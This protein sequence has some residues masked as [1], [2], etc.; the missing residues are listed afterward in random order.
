MLVRSRGRGVNRLIR[1]FHNPG[2]SRTEK[3]KRIRFGRRAMALIGGLA[4]LSVFSAVW[5]T[6]GDKPV[7]AKSP[8]C[9]S[10]PGHQSDTDI[11]ALQWKYLQLAQRQPRVIGL[12]NFGFWTGTPWTGGGHGASDLPSTVDAHERI[13]ARVLSAAGE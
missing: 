13:A 11:A 6:I 3:M 10:T 4:A 7:A 1:I 12:L 2:H 9:A 5:A 8:A